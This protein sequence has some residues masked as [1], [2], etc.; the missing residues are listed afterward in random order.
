MLSTLRSCPYFFNSR[1]F[2]EGYTKGLGG[3]FHSTMGIV[4]L[5]GIGIVII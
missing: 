4:E 5:V 1:G 3:I 2:K